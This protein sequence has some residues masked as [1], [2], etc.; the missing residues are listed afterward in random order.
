M[1]EDK[2]FIEESEKWDSRELGASVDHTQ[3]ASEEQSQAVL[4]ALDLQL[5]SIRLQ[6]GLIEDL[7]FIAKAHGI[8]YQPLVRDILHRFVVSEKKLIMR[9]ILEQKRIE[10][11]MIEATNTVDKETELQK[12]A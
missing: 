7:K 12:I 8:G 1:S 5:I 11:E 10:L 9:D 3:V 6:K 2:R 4:D